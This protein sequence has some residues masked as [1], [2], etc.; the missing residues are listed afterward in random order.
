M[1]EAVR[2][3]PFCVVLLD[4]IEK[5]NSL[6]ARDLQYIC[7]RTL[8]DAYALTPHDILGTQPFLV[9]QHTLAPSSRKKRRYEPLRPPEE[10][11]A[12]KTLLG[13]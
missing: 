11:T 3:R 12:C 1:T 2:T 13:S 10:Q 6:R 9:C 7:K 5:A 8:Y 4:E